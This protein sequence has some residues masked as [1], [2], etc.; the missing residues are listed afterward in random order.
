MQIVTVDYEVGV[1]V[2]CGFW[3]VRISFRTFVWGGGGVNA[4]ADL[5]S[6][7]MSGRYG[8]DRWCAYM[9]CLPLNSNVGIL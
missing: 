9:C 4:V 5:D 8:T 1:C 7:G 3:S 6:S 2:V